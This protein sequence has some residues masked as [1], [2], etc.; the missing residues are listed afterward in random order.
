[1]M[2][3]SEIRVGSPSGQFLRL[4]ESWG[5]LGQR[6]EGCVRRRERDKQKTLLILSG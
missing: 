1:M 4:G 2:G 5:R 6:E 3:S